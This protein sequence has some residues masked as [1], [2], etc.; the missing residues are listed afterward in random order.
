MSLIHPNPS[1]DAVANEHRCKLS[2]H[3]FGLGSGEHA[4]DKGLLS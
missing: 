4:G 1:L 3:G 2:E